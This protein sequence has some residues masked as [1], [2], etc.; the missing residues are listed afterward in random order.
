MKT[1]RLSQHATRRALLR[2]ATED[3]I[4]VALARGTREPARRAKWQVRWP[5]DYGGASPVD[6]RRY[7]R[8]TVEVIFADEPDEIVVVT[9][10]VYYSDREDCRDED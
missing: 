5:F 2:G 10:K 1:I 9:V 7:R 3:E 8:K 6:G 4:R